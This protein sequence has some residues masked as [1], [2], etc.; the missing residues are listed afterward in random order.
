MEGHIEMKDPTGEIT[1]VYYF[2]PETS[3]IY[4]PLK[5]GRTLVLN[6]FAKNTLPELKIDVETFDQ[7]MST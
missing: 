2:D 4:K 7:L 1:D 3:K 5:D 6:P